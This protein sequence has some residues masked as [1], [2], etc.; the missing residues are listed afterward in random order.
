MTTAP[1]CSAV[2]LTAIAPQF[3]VDDL[4]TAVACYR[5]TL[6]YNG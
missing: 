3:L 1:V 6:G 5:D 2:R 4:A